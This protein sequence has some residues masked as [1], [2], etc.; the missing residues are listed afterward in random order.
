MSSYLPYFE[1]HT[2]PVQTIFRASQSLRIYSHGSVGINM[3]RGP[4]HSN[5][6]SVGFGLSGYLVDFP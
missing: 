5:L 3:E 2:T 1:H 4:D 6:A